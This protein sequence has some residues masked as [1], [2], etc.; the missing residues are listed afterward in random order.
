MFILVFLYKFFKVR[1]VILIFKICLKDEE[2]GKVCLWY[3]VVCYNDFD[4]V[5]YKFG[6]KCK[7]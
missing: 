4:E 7:F 2:V 5:C 6:S 3:K 1:G